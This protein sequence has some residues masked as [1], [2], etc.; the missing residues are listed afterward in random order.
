MISKEDKMIRERIRKNLILL[1]TAFGVTQTDVGKIVG[2]TKTAVA[3]WEQGLS[4][5]DTTTMYK[6]AKSYGVS[7]DFLYGETPESRSTK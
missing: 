6:L 2:K 5:P 4:L 1:R 3:S 7:V